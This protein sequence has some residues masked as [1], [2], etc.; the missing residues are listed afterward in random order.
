MSWHLIWQVHVKVRLQFA[1]LVALLALPSWLRGQ[2]NAEP[3]LP[4]FGTLLG[5]MGTAVDRESYYQSTFNQHYAYL[6]SRVTEI[7]YSD[8]SF[9]ARE[10]KYNTNSPEP[11]LAAQPLPEYKPAV[12]G[13]QPDEKQL[14]DVSELAT[15]VLAH[16][17]LTVVG[18]EILDGRSMLVVDFKPP[19]NRVPDDSLVDDLINRGAGRAWIDEED[20]TLAK[21]E[22][23]LLEK[24]NLYGGFAGAI[25]SG[26]YSFERERTP[27]GL[28]YSRDI[29]WNADVREFIVFRKLSYHEKFTDVHKPMAAAV[30]SAGSATTQ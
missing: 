25:Y 29:Q 18:R 17:Q 3:S 23:H 1:F 10:E 2:T 21:L 6:R 13:S 9:K 16:A 14:I 4:P 8:G 28:W 20:Y 11:L 27:E 26:S 24:L 7:C 15:N 30:A 19:V 5:R 22:T 12:G